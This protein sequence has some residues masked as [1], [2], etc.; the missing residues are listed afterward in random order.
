[1]VLPPAFGEDL[2]A[3]LR[4]LLAR[5]VPFAFGPPFFDWSTDLEL[6][7]IRDRPDSG[8]RAN[9]VGVTAG[10]SGYPYGA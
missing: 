5:D 7:R 4:D 2:A 3:G 6:N 8:L 10:C 9:L 1:M